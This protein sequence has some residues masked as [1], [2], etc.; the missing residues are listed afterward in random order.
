MAPQTCLHPSHVPGEAAGVQ[1][2]AVT[3]RAGAVHGG[4]PRCCSHRSPA[5][6]E[7]KTPPAALLQLLA[8]VIFNKHSL[9]KVGRETDEK[10]KLIYTLN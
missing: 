2:I 9:Q 10:I 8:V 7:A 4:P 1:A 3:A 6:E 5:T